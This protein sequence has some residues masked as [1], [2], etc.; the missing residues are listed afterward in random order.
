LVKRGREP[1][2]AANQRGRDKSPEASCGRGASVGQRVGEYRRAGCIGR[3]GGIRLMTKHEMAKRGGKD[4]LWNKRGAAMVIQHGEA[5]VL[6]TAADRAGQ[7]GAYLSKLKGGRS[8]H[9]A[10]TY[11]DGDKKDGGDRGR[12]RKNSG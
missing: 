10:A 8:P 2:N 1:W 9:S 7:R 6:S 12:G 4:S 5:I 11:D 3:G